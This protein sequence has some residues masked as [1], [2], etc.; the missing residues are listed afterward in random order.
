MVKKASTSIQ[1]RTKQKKNHTRLNS[2]E[3]SICFTLLKNTVC[4]CYDQLR[5]SDNLLGM[6]GRAGA[7]ANA[8][9]HARTHARSHARTA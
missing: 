8:R 1:K 2:E 9:T 7:R 3:Y 4:M 5:N 6:R